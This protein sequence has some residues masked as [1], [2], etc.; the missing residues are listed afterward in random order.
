MDH[1]LR[2]PSYFPFGLQ[3]LLTN[4]THF[5]PQG[6]H[7]GYFLTS[8][9]QLG[10]KTP[11]FGPWSPRLPHFKSIG[12]QTYFGLATYKEKYGQTPPNLLEES[13][14]HV[15]CEFHDYKPMTCQKK[16]FWP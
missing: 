6:T 4:L 14:Q 8:W 3:S 9:L 10:V 7:L 11:M 15:C 5:D 12:D 2:V 1:L 16:S 13:V